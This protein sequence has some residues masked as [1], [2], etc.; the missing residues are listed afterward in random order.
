[1]DDLSKID[2]RG[3]GCLFIEA[4]NGLSVFK[5]IYIDKRELKFACVGGNSNVPLGF[6]S[7]TEN[8]MMAGMAIYICLLDFQAHY[9]SE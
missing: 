4:V 8:I 5:A 1:M 6:V 3:C 7:L 2:Y 9:S